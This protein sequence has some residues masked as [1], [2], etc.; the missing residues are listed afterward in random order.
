MQVLYNFI[1]ILCQVLI[2]AIFLRAILS[3]FMVSSS[4]IFVVILHQVT[5]PILAPLRRVIPRIGL[6]DITPM[7]AI[8]ILILIMQLVP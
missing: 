3:W 5:E 8:L 4:N 2:V 6:I 7:I 1:E